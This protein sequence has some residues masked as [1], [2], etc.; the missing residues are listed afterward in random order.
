MNYIYCS[1]GLTNFIKF[2]PFNETPSQVLW[3]SKV[4]AGKGKRPQAAL[5][6]TSRI[7]GLVRL[8][9]RRPCTL[10]RG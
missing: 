1:A 6:V 8:V 3:V 4:H 10:V 9:M 5:F 2:E 7:V